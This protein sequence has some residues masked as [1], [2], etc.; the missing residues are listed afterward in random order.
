MTLKI[1][2]IE[3]LNAERT[4]GNWDIKDKFGLSY[5]PI[6]VAYSII[7]TNKMN[8]H[9]Y[10]EG[11]WCFIAA[12]PTITE[13]YIRARKFKVTTEFIDK[14]FSLHTHRMQGRMEMTNHLTIIQAAI[15]AMW[16]TI[17]EEKCPALA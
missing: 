9:E 7:Q 10:S 2:E 6:K 12:A 17:E 8:I 13:Q 14:A 3:K 15:D 4:P 11:N 5:T 16:E 1:E